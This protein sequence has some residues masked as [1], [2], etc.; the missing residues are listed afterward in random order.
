M[1]FFLKSCIFGTVISAFGAKLAFAMTIQTGGLVGN[2]RTV[3]YSNQES[4]FSFEYP[5]DWQRLSVELGTV[6]QEKM[7]NSNP[8]LRTGIQFLGVEVDKFRVEVKKLKPNDIAQGGLLE[9]L[10]SRFP[11]NNWQKA[12]IGT[13]DAY[14]YIDLDTSR[15]YLQGKDDNVYIISNPVDRDGIPS[16]PVQNI[17]NSFKIGTN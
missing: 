4:H 10:N 16:L 13:H 7:A 17:M 1:K 5:E 8:I 9:Y 3:Q 15:V 12:L 14:Q 2:G 11:H 6:V